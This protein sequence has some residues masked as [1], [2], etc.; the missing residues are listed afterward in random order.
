M[1]GAAPGG[2]SFSWWHTWVQVLGQFLEK[3][4]RYLLNYLKGQNFF[5]TKVYLLL[6]VKCTTYSVTRLGDLLHF[7]Q[8][9]KP[10]ATTIMPKFTAFLV[11][12]EK[13]SK[14]FIIL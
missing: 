5:N 6:Y 9:L 2:A 12:F 10:T 1:V 3:I 11:I 7:G 14:S 4:P 8:L 13:L